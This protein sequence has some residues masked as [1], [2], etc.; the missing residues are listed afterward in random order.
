MRIVLTGP[1][2]AGKGTQ[3]QILSQAL[4]LPHISTGE[5][6]RNHIGIGTDLGQKA[7][8]F[9]D[10]GKL[11]PSDITVDMVRERL[12]VGDTDGGF[13]LD[14]F[15]RTVEQSM[16]LDDLLNEQLHQVNAVLDFV[17]GE[18]VAVDRMMGRARADD[19]EDVIR[20]RLHVYDRENQPLISHYAPVLLRVDGEG[21]VEDV[22]SR[23]MDALAERLAVVGHSRA[24]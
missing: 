4:Q 11:V 19:T 13:I 24:R 16:A 14:G 9:I 23:A 8:S 18:G 1:P 5:L 2:G 6:F 10:A 22:H 7:K 21:T 12:A 15:P 3:A 20:A 17:V